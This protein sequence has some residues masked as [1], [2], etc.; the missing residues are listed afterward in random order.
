M[1]AAAG[2]PVTVLMVNT[3]TS[4]TNETPYEFLCRNGLP[5]VPATTQITL[6]CELGV[7]NTGR[8]DRF[9]GVTMALLAFDAWE[10]AA[11][12][13]EGIAIAPTKGLLLTRDPFKCRF[14]KACQT[15]LQW[16]AEG[17]PAARPGWPLSLQQHVVAGG[18]FEAGGVENAAK[19]C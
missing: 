9:N 18:R 16:S 8:Q 6:S 1:A 11:P 3:L 4:K 12:F 5:G 14:V 19:R 15:T 10:P 2:G 7:S 17:P 13:A